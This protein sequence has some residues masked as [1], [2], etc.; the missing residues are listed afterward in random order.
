MRL[1]D[2]Q[3]ATVAYAKSADLRLLQ[4]AVDDARMI[5]PGKGAGPAAPTKSLTW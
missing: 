4:A 3:E 2:T 5:T 1:P